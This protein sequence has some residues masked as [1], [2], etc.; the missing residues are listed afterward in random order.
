M[1]GRQPGPSDEAA[2]C[3]R[4]RSELPFRRPDLP[5]APAAAAGS[6]MGVWMLLRALELFCQC[7]SCFVCA[8]LRLK[9]KVWSSCVISYEAKTTR[10]GLR[11]PSSHSGRLLDICL[12]EA[13]IPP[14]PLLAPGEEARGAAARACGAPPPPP[15]AGKDSAAARAA[16]K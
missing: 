1:S 4:G 7:G 8:G 12:L 3:A 5:P 16:T 14:A 10:I 9:F 15:H 11:E 6:A 2:Q 13:L